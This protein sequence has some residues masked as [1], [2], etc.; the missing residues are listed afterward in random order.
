MTQR[1]I[2]TITLKDPAGIEHSC[3]YWLR[4]RPAGMDPNTSFDSYL[5]KLSTGE[6]FSHPSAHGCQIMIKQHF[7]AIGAIVIPDDNSHLDDRDTLIWAE[8]VA[9]FNARGPG[10]PRVGDFL[11]M[12]DGQITRICMNHDDGAQTTKA[13]LAS[14]HMG[15]SGHAS[16]SGGLDPSQLY[17]YMK[18][19]P[20]TKRG[21]FWFF[22]H[23]AP[24]AGR[25]VEA[26][27]D[28]RV[29]KLERFKMTQDQAHAH[30]S[31]RSKARCWG[32]NDSI[33]LAHM[34]ELMNGTFGD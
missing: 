34:A 11:E 14:Y 17:D 27:T 25:G 28:C 3:Q 5:Y 29:F 21:R 18:L 32:E 26:W 9:A 31:T 8:N 10:R 22:H 15:S 4:E 12:P 30:P 2:Q 20:E 24:G 33:T 13:L 7:V 19:Q 23:R 16:Y 1:D 6:T